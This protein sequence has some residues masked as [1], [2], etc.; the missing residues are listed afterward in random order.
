MVGHV[1]KK[2]KQ[3][4]NKNGKIIEEEIDYNGCILKNNIKGQKNEKKL[5]DSYSKRIEN[6]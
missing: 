4:L 2:T 6:M 1:D 3:K 5:I